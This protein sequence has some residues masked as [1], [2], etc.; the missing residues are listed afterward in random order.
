[1]ET[2]KKQWQNKFCT[3]TKLEKSYLLESKSNKYEPKVFVFLHDLLIYGCF[4]SNTVHNIS[5][6]FSQIKL[7]TKNMETINK[8]LDALK[9]VK[10]LFYDA[11]IL[12]NSAKCIL[13]KYFI[14]D[15][16][17]DYEYNDFYKIYN[18]DTSTNIYKSER[19]IKCLID[20]LNNENIN[21]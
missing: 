15:S 13:S 12:Q 11:Y 2:E 19:E 3:I 16:N 14:I 17:G 7:K 10:K 18:I 4:D 6:F 9:E 20:K 21:L 1:M 5:H 8:K